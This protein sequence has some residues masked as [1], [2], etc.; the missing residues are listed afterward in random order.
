MKQAPVKSS[1]CAGWLIAALQMFAHRYDVCWRVKPVQALVMCCKL[2]PFIWSYPV[3]TKVNTPTSHN[4]TASEVNKIEDATCI[5][6]AWWFLIS[7]LIG[8]SLFK[9]QDRMSRTISPHR[10]ARN[11]SQIVTESAVCD[12]IKRQ[13]LQLPGDFLGIRNGFSIFELV[14]VVWN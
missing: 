14:A 4:T 6:S 1:S 9:F 10:K 12:F 3:I 5:L 2:L 7:W 13:S 11:N 8:A